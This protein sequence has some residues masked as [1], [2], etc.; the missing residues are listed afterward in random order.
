MVRQLLILTGLCACAVE[1]STP[2]ESAIAQHASF[3]FQREHVV[4][5]IYHYELVLPVGSTPNAAVRVH[6]VVREVAPFVPRRTPHAA[7]MLHGDFATFETNFAPTLGQPASPAS[8]L[9]PYL[10]AQGVDVWGVDR[11]WTLPAPEDDVSD[12]ATMGVAQEVDD[13]RAALAVARALRLA[14]GSGGGK[15]ALVGFS[16]GGQL[17]YIYAAAEAARPLALRHVDAVVPLDF[18]GAYGPEQAAEQAAACTN[19]ALGYEYV[20][21]GFIDSDNSFQILV[22]QLA[23][24]APDDV[25]PIDPA[26]TNRGMML[27]LVGET[28]RFVPITP[29]YQLLAPILDGETAIGLAETSETAAIAW[30][31]GSP[32]HQAFLE[33]VDFDAML[34][35]A[36]PPVDAP[37]SR[38]TAPVFYLGAANGVGELG[39]YAT[40]QVASTDVTTLVVPEFGHADLL[41]AHDAETL[42]WQPL[43]AWL[44][45]R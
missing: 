6:R 45:T 14:G 37:L 44:V 15:L 16:H 31:E 7:M 2:D 11:R 23:R 36:N 8:G 38:I 21:Q 5:D 32:F 41:F 12:F 24:T 40:T 20:A 17:A 26:L 43:A 35:G 29:T 18:F 27:R 25:S 19:S 34:C 33:T 9:A 3:A 39:V 30:L 22:G 28:Y 4:D 1:D 10:A 42:A 13:V